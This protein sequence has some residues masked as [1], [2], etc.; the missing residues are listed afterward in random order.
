M[1]YDH[2]FTNVF[3]SLINRQVN[4]L[5]KIQA[6][7]PHVYILFDFY[8]FDFALPESKQKLVLFLYHT[9]LPTLMNR[10]CNTHCVYYPYE[11]H[12]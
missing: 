1:N 4:V 2:F 6:K 7:Q 3:K 12:R 8:I 11:V 5:N 10:E 9:V